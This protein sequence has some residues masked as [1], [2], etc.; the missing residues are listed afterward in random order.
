MSKL[1]LELARNIITQI[2]E[3]QSSVVEGVNLSTMHPDDG[4]VHAIADQIEEYFVERKKE[5][6]NRYRWN[7]H[8]G[9]I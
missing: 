4:F 8:L 1:A 9:D 7:P 6:N 3:L 5:L 2:D